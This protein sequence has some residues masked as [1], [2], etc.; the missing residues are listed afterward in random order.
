MRL[1][2]LIGLIYEAA[3][4]PARWGEVMERLAQFYEG[5]AVL[6]ADDGEAPEASV[7]GLGL[8]DDG[9]IQKYQQHYISTNIWTPLADGMAAGG[10]V[11]S[12][13]IPAKEFEASEFYNGWLE[14]Q[15][16]YHSLGFI[17]A[18]QQNLQTRLS[19]L[20]PRRVGDFDK[21]E[22]R[23]WRI[24]GSHVQRAFQIHRQL[25][26]ARL[27]RDAARLGLDRLGVAAFIA[28]AD[29]QILSVNSAGA[30]MLAQRDGL[31]E[32][33]GRLAAL[34]PEET[35]RL[36]RLIMEAA[37]TAAGRS[38]NSGGIVALHRGLK[39][40]L[41]AVVSP[42]WGEAFDA[43]HPLPAA[44]VFVRDPERKAISRPDA[45]KN[46]FGLTD[47][48][49]RIASAL[50]DGLSVQDIADEN[51]ITIATARTHVKRLMEKAGVNRQGELISLILR[52]VAPLNDD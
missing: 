43:G 22:F 30:T 10:I 31:I 39:R 13:V 44:L 32:V 3:L 51:G 8:F 46:L 50:A 37:E 17:V 48:E 19:I 7:F 35:D 29:G 23:I 2:E 20:R 21:D 34:W 47:A 26:I 14:P 6:F 12:R 25:F 15:D 40:P 33:A 49:A 5:R 36:H 27:E 45:L 52:S 24:I 9:D 42:M 41:T 38:V 28:D 16:L 18:N 11:D 1:Q 4:E